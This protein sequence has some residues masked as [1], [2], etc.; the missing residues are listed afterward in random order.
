MSKRLY[1][2]GYK[3]EKP[4]NK[5]PWIKVVLGVLLVIALFIGSFSI[6]YY[7][8]A[9]SGGNKTVALADKKDYNSMTKDELIKQVTDL[10]GQITQ[11][12]QKIDELTNQMQ[13]YKNVVDSLNISKIGESQNS[14]SYTTQNSVKPTPLPTVNTEEKAIATITPVVIPKPTNT[15]FS[16]A[17]NT[18]TQK[19]TYGGQ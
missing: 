3:S 8:R 11:K 6:S 13:R 19:S 14:N 7:L 15:D 18:T 9:N 2:P 1:V 4:F 16:N 12:N 10:N 5:R 17:T